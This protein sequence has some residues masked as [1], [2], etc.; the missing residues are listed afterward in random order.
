MPESGPNRSTGIRVRACGILT[1]G[2]GLVMVNHGGLYGHDFWL[3][4]GGGLERG[5]RIGETLIREFSEECG[6]KVAPGAFLFA[7][8]VVRGHIHAVEFFHRVERI[9]GDLLVGTDPEYGTRQII[10]DVRHLTFEEIAALPAGHRHPVFTLLEHPSE[11]LEITGFF[12][13]T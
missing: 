3:P 6:L 13:V 12:E 10:S 9:G 11:I 5:E 2:A 8:N 1:D 7:C 4:P